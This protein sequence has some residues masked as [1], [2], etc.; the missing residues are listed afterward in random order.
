M[1][2]QNNIKL[3]KLKINPP[4]VIR[5]FQPGGGTYLEKIP[6][7]RVKAFYE[8]F[9]LQ[10]ALI[11]QDE[12]GYNYSFTSLLSG[13]AVKKGVT[14]RETVER[15]KAVFSKHGGEVVTAVINDAVKKYGP[16]IIEK[17]D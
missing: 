10:F 8:V 5:I 6:Q 7:E 3:K 17:E 2:E 1:T 4:V 15:A 9:G 12:P 16:A 13:M 11:E 14:K